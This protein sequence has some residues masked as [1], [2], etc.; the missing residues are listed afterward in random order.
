MI[1]DSKVRYENHLQSVFRRV[2]K[3]IILLRKFQSTLPRKSLVTI[4]K[5]FIRPYLDYGDVIYDRASKESFHKSLESLQYSAAIAITGGIRGTSSEKLFQELGLETLKSRSWLR[6]LCLF[7]KSIK[8]QSA[9]YLFQLIPENKI[10]YTTRN[11]QKSQIPFSKRKTNFFK[12]Y[13]F[14]SVILEW[15]KLDVN[16]RNSASCNILKR[17]I[18]TFITAESN[19]V[20]N[21]DSSEGLKFLTRIRLGLS[22]LAD[23]KFRHNFQDCVYP[24]C[25]CGQGI[26]TS[27]HFLLHCSNYHCARQTLIEKRKKID[28][29]TLKENDQLI[30]NFCYLAMKN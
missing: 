24:V 28:S 7:Y 12:N 27:T 11:V 22:H 4:H 13:F 6:K 5:S 25:S 3:T 30:K 21:V 26:E 29:N 19:H 8:E 2:N 23:H 10:P 1:L 16:I 18:L 14:V 17:V 20:F 9:A 15:N